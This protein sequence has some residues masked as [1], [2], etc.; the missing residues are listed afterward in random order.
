MKWISPAIVAAALLLSIGFYNRL[1]DEVPIHWNAAGEVNGYASRATGAF[2][3]P[4]ILLLLAVLFPVLPRIS[5]RGYLLD[6]ES[7]GYRAIWIT[8]MLSMLAVHVFALLAATGMRVNMSMAMPIVIGALFIVLGNYI[9]TVP[10]N[11]FVGIRTPWTLASED[12]WFR[13]HRFGGRLF[14]LG[15]VV[16]MLLPLFGP[17]VL[18][19]GLIA[20]VLATA[21][22]SVVYSYVIYRREA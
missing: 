21:L 14:M 1:P 12:V 13:T 17:R 15:G 6:T 8:T 10:R 20:V 16:L 5:P 22:G 2:L 9:T 11:F 7:R 19:A 18:E 4:G 3:M